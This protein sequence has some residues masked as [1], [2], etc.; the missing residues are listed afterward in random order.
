MTLGSCMMMRAVDELIGLENTRE[1]LWSALSLARPNALSA[2]MLLCS[3]MI[4]TRVALHLHS[5]QH[6]LQSLKFDCSRLACTCALAVHLSNCFAPLTIRSTTHL[7][8]KAFTQIAQR[9]TA[10]GEPGA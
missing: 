6:D 7:M 4:W 3:G 5:L 9:I 8:I 2:A 1:S 10:P